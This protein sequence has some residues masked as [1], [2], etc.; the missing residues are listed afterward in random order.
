MEEINLTQFPLLIQK[1]MNKKMLKVIW[2]VIVILFIAMEVYHVIV[3]NFD[4]LALSLLVV[5]TLLSMIGLY[6]LINK[7]RK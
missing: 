7:D 3:G 4:D 2:L 1:I 5:I 6:F